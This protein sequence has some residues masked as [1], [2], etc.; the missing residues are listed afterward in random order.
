MTSKQPADYEAIIIGGG[1]AGLTA[2][3]YLARARVRTMLVE[4]GLMGGQIV[5]A[6]LVENYPGFPQG[7]SG[8]QLGELMSQQA[9]KY[10]LT[11]L[12]AEVTGIELRGQSKV[13]KT[14]GGDLQAKAL[15][16]AGGSEPQKLGVRG[17]ELLTGRG[18]SYCATCDGPLFRDETVAVV[19]GGNVA[20]TDALALVTFVKK[21][22]VIH[23]REELR[24]SKVLQEKAFAEPKISF[25]WNTV[26]EEVTGEDRV[27]SLRLK[28]LKTNRSFDLKVAGAFICVGHKPNTGLVAGLMKLDPEGHIIADS[29]MRTEMPGIF[30]AGDL[31]QFSVRQVVAA[32]GDGAVAALSAEKFLRGL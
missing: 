20:I 6:H 19:G 3:L 8:A 29:Q 23:R 26:V 31:R 28:D 25:L 24:A 18:V 17:E 1:P 7:V 22:I 32:A 12:S 30:A 2:G 13:V 5:N 21:V 14:A 4:R 10:G 15:I 27:Q 16:I 9:L 11:T